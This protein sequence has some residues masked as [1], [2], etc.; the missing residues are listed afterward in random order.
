MD[1]KLVKG[2]DWQGLYINNKLDNQG[3]RID[4]DDVITCVNENIDSLNSG[5]KI[6][7]K[8]YW[9]DIKWLEEEAYLPKRFEDVKLEDG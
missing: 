4:I 6:T 1:I 9:C 3:H 5:N 2:D 8:S 7:F